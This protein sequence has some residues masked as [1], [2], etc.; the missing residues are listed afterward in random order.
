M[1]VLCTGISA[2]WCPR[3]GDCICERGSDGDCHHDNDLCPLHGSDSKHAETIE[4]M[5]CREK[6]STLAHDCGVELT[7]HDH[8]TVARFAQFLFERSR[9]L[10]K[11]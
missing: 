11:T 1:I 3:C 6:V 9:K 10:K 7:A 4:L 2:F 5:E 8:E